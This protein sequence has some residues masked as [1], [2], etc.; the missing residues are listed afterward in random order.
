M[1]KIICFF[2]SKDIEW[3]IRATFVMFIGFPSVLYAIL[4]ALK[5]IFGK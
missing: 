5:S 4:L 1:K 2:D 3:S